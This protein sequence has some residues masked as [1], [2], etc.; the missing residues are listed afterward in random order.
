M[1]PSTASPSGRAQLTQRLQKSH[2]DL[3]FLLLAQDAHDWLQY[4]SF[5]LSH[6]GNDFPGAG[7]S[8]RSRV[9]FGFHDSLSCE[10]VVDWVIAEQ[11]S[12]GLFQTKCGQDRFENFWVFALGGNASLSRATSFFEMIS[13][14]SQAAGQTASASGT[15]PG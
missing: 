14:Q 9:H 8:L 6:H 2:Y 5:R 13:D 7:V 11:K 1:L 12:Q 4:G 3:V 15:R 10:I